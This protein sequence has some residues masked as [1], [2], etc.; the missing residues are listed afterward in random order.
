MS[1]HL[2]DESTLAAL[3]FEDALRELELIVKKLE[4]GKESLVGGIAAYERAHQLRQHCEQQLR[5]ARLKV[6]KIMKQADGN[7]ALVPFAENESATTS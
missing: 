5:D 4:S 7:I 1:E 6:E 3:S 2:Y